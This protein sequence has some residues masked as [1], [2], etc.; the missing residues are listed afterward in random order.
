MAYLVSML[1]V[2]AGA[3]VLFT[4]LLRLAVPARRLAGA[5]RLSGT[6]FANRTGILAARLVALRVE[7]DRRRHRKRNSEGSHPTSPA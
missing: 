6:R 4:L 1:A 5:V 7:L 2:A 3:V